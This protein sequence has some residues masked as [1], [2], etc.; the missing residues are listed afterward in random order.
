MIEN[1]FTRIER[2]DQPNR[3]QAV[4]GHGQ[5][6]YVS[7][8]G[9]NYC[10]MHGG[11]KAQEAAKKKVQRGYNLAQWQNRVDDF[12][13]GD[14]VK[15]LRA[16][17]GILKM[18]LENVVNMCK[19]SQDLLLYSSKIGEMA[20]KIEKLVV[21]CSRLESSMG[22]MLDK[23]AALHLA[24]MMVEIISKYVT[25]EDAV[26]MIANDIA[27]AVVSLNGKDVKDK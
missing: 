26:D 4:H 5:C 7:L 10:A 18:L 3:C 22:M 27:L 1:K 12:S 8:E 20:S 19:T 9:S 25:D 24:A 14:N 2:D 21:S 6:Q 11:N 16:E 15:N 23:S 13:D 17:I